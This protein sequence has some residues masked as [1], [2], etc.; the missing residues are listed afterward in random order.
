[1]VAFEALAPH[2][3][4][5]RRNVKV[6]FIPDADAGNR[7]RGY[8]VLI[9]DI[10]EMKWVEQQLHEAVRKRDETLALLDTLLDAAPVGFAF[11]DTQFRWVR[12]N[13]ALAALDGV[14][15]ETHIGR[16]ASELLPE[17]GPKVEALL[18]RVPETGQPAVN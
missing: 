14:D 12:V 2:R 17:V 1:K 18:R 6:V 3:G 16:R 9:H 13:D 4:G 10:S 15:R 8:F 11:Q 7:V 5:E